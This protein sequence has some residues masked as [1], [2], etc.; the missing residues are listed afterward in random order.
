MKNKMFSAFVTPDRAFRGVPF[1]ALNGKLSEPAMRDEIRSFREMGFGGFFFHSRT[2]L[3]TPYLSDEWFHFFGIALDEA[4][5]CGLKVWIYDEDRWP[6]GTA[7]G[8]VTRDARYRVRYLVCRQDDEVDGTPCVGRFAACFAD[9]VLQNYRRLADGD[10]PCPGETLLTFHRH[11][12]DDDPW[13]NGSCYLDT[14]NPLAVKAF[15][16]ATHEAY[17]RRFGQY[18]GNIIAGFFSDEPNFNSFPGGK[19]LPW[20]DDFD[21]TF[22][23]VYHYDLVD[24]LPELFFT[25]PSAV[26]QTRIDFRNHLTARF[27]AAFGK[28]IGDWCKAHG[29]V[30][31]G[32]LLGEDTLSKMARNVGSAMRFYCT[33]QMPGIDLLT[34]HALVFN[35]VK[36]CVSSARQNGQVR[37]L[38]ECYG[39]TGWDFS[40]AGYRA[41]GEWQYA[42]G[43]NF[44]CLHHAL[45]TLQGDA[46]RDYPASIA[47][48]SPWAKQFRA[49]EDHFAR[50]GAALAPG[51]E[52][53]HTLVIHPAE[54]AFGRIVG[55][56]EPAENDA[57]VA[58]TNQLLSHQIDFDFGDEEI[59]SRSGAIADRELVVGAAS[60]TIAIIPEVATLRAT[61]L[62]LL[63]RLAQA[64]GKVFYLGKSPA[65]LD[66]APSD[67]PAKVYRKFSMFALAEITTD[68]QVTE[69]G[70]AVESV[71]ALYKRGQNFATLYLV[72]TGCDFNLKQCEAPRVVDRKRD[73]FDAQVVW[74]VAESYQL[75]RLFPETGEIFHHPFVRE[76]QKI[77]FAAP[78]A[79]LES[80]LF[81]ASCEAFP[82]ALPHC[83][84]QKG[85]ICQL[86]DRPVAV[87]LEEENL[88]VLDEMEC[89]ADGVKLPGKTFLQQDA[90]LLKL[91]GAPPRGG[92]QPWCQTPRPPKHTFQ[93]E[94]R[95]TFQCEAV[96]DGMLY[97]ALENPELYEITLN[98][99]AVEKV[100]AGF[101][102][103]FAIRK[104]AFP[105]KMLKKGDNE[106][107]LKRRFDETMPGLECCFLFGNF[108]VRNDVLIS[109]VTHLKYGD[110]TKQGLP[111]YTGNVICHFEL[112]AGTKFIRF[113]ALGATAVENVE[114]H[115]IS[116]SADFKLATDGKTK[117]AVRLL[118]SRRNAFGPFYL[119]DH[120]QPIRRGAP[121]QFAQMECDQKQLVASGV[122]APPEIGM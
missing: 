100:D 73:H 62:D 121:G 105:G 42:L 49:V 1:W 48:Q 89:F 98:G 92:I 67:L 70:N 53:C 54:S 103:D 112:P 40:F 55:T 19:T 4:Q 2:G 31:T 6:S 12:G 56:A 14:L 86:E 75:Y 15:V 81:V 76:G 116:M 71:L 13:F 101:W 25:T 122:F 74:Q 11:L 99:N 36:Q 88:L 29:V 50:L 90:A 8:S 78:L 77:R 58:L 17:F 33:M 114:T 52:V 110:W 45:Y 41:L 10:A 47:T 66:G 22:Q 3:T 60:Y 43:I 79:A 34:E 7:G 69:N 5:K 35:T 94:L 97:F 115:A 120:H 64:G 106:I 63:D 23:S 80:S 84:P 118:G 32:H 104:L 119:D 24:R 68:F 96:P 21:K 109:P 30:F 87:T 44:R 72:N 82:E 37:R 111:Y 26:V 83:P 9:G 38:T 65:L 28:T 93:I 95:R 27:D 51:K 91:C 20:T 102:C 85:K 46:K 107:L 113:P 18:F 108:G 57:L 61:T 59:L 117:F 39:C 16:E